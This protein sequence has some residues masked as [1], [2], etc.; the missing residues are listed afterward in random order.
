M[1]ADD[2]VQYLI[3]PACRSKLTAEAHDLSCAQCKAPYGRTASGYDFSSVPLPRNLAAKVPLWD[4]LQAN[5]SLSYRLAP[6][7]NLATAQRADVAA[8]RS[9]MRLDGRVLDIGC[10]P[11]ANVPGYVDSSPRV[12]YVGLD[13]LE[14]RRNFLHIKGVAELLPFADG[15]FDQIIF[16]T[17]LDHLLDLGLSL[18][19]AARVLKPDGRIYLWTDNLEHTQDMSSW[20][21]RA[22]RIVARGSEQLFAGLK[23]MGFRPTVRYFREAV[24]MR[25]PEGA[26]DYFHVMLPTVD[27]VVRALAAAGLHVV[28]RSVHERS[29]FLEARKGQG[30]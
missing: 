5:G 16:A 2:L 1:N 17:S 13:P 30:T 12:D 26:V 21:T 11:Q 24:R 29:L 4:V 15:T 20:L 27:D 10:G 25:V 22:V 18:N 9:F 7:L 8:F 19:E 23:R 14:G 3:C 6:E 28:T